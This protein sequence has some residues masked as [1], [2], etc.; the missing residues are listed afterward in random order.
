MKTARG[1]DSGT[2]WAGNLHKC[3]DKR[4]GKESDPTPEPGATAAG[5]GNSGNKPPHLQQGAPGVPR[6]GDGDDEDEGP[7]KGRRDEGPARRSKGPEENEKEEE[8]A[9]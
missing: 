8:E 9:T 4:Q 7:E 6:G 2:I 3:S 1:K 5:G